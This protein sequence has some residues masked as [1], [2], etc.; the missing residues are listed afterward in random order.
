MLFG[1]SLFRLRKPPFLGGLVGN[2]ASVCFSGRVSCAAP[3]TE[4]LPGPLDTRCSAP[5]LGSVLD[6]CSSQLRNYRLVLTPRH[7][8]LETSRS[9]SAPGLRPSQV[10][11]PRQPRSLT[12]AIAAISAYRADSDSNGT[13]SGYFHDF[14]LGTPE[15]PIIAAIISVTA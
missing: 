2:R 11:R 14:G 4:K 6:T 3:F 15:S 10:S 13:V 1:I 5:V 8:P 7:S 12:E 9:A